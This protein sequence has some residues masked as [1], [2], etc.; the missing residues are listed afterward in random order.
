MTWN[1]I[2]TKIFDTT[3]FWG[4]D[5]RFWLGL[6]VILLLV[7]LMECIAWHLANQVPKEK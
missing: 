7:C 6:S 1:I 4:I 5:I 3:T 2:L